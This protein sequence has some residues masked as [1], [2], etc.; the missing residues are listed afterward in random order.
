[1]SDEEREA[2]IQQAWIRN[3]AGWTRAIGEQRIESR[4]AATDAAILDAVLG[5][6]PR[7]VLD[8]GCGEGWLSRALAKE[9]VDVVGFDGSS[10]LIEDARDAGGASF[11]ALSYEAFA[12][13]PSTVGADYDVAVCNFSLL[14]RHI[15]PLLNACGSVLDADGRLVIQTVHP[16]N[17]GEAEPYA[18]GWR[19]EEFRGIGEGFHASMPWYFRTFSS[20][21]G[22]L[23]RARFTL[24]D[25]REPQ[26]PGRGGPASLILVA[27]RSGEPGR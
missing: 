12:A 3:A 21:V 2:E 25:V 5:Q 7:R 22:E 24:A 11:L 19:R 6:R 20:W 10:A 17:H 8:V 27:R 4:R 13:R 18:D 9:G 23:C 26:L 15:G 1:M 16:L 14:G